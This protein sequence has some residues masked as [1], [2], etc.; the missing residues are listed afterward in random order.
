[1]YDEI[2]F[3]VTQMIDI[4]IYCI[5]FLK[6]LILEQYGGVYVDLDYLQERQ[7]TQLHTKFDSYTV[8]EGLGRTG[9]S[10]GIIGVKK[11]HVAMKIWKELLIE[12]YAIRP[13]KWGSH[14]VLPIP[15]F[16]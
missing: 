11:N 15:A 6:A 5:D 2:K 9:I 4:K 13:D 1:M 3:V 12:Y 8:F 7:L 10:T 14:L 16:I